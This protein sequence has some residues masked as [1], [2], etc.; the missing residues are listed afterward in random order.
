MT[1]RRILYKEA[2]QRAFRF[3]DG[4]RGEEGKAWLLGL[5]RIFWPIQKLE[6]F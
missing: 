1:M 2:Y 5:F 6:A 4:F 3:F